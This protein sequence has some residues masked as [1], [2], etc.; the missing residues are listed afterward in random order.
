MVKKH[1]KLQDKIDKMGNKIKHTRKLVLS[2]FI[3]S[4]QLNKC[5]HCGGYDGIHRNDCSFMRKYW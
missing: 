3:K 1:K 2:D 5:E 4:F